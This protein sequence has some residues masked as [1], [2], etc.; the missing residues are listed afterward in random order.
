MPDEVCS[1]LPAC[2]ITILGV[3]SARA[4]HPAAYG[5]AN[6]T[7]AEIQDDEKKD[8]QDDRGGNAF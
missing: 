4:G 8:K 5:C 1:G 2:L 7:N 3:V 6:N